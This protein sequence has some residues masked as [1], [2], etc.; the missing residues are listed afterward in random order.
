[1]IRLATKADLPELARLG[2][3]MHDQ[4]TYAGLDYDE[5]AVASTLAELIDKS[6][7]VSV[8]EAKNGTLTAV[9]VGMVTKSWF[10]Q[11]SIAT[12]LALF[13]ENKG[14]MAAVRLVKAFVAWARM[15]GA[16]QIRPAVS[17][18]DERAVLFYER[19]GFQKTG[20]TFVMSGE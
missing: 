13:T 2:R 3:L 15:A 16:K 5:Q 6:Q 17:T 11:D 1:M 18:G 12:E 4:S 9:M 19:L 7:F 14:G 20:A 10:G 8:N